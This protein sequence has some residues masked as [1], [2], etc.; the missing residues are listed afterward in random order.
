MNHSSTIPQ[1]VRSG[2][3]APALIG[4]CTF[5]VFVVVQ[6][7]AH[8]AFVARVAVDL[9][10]AI[11][12]ACREW[13]IW[14][15]ITPALFACVRHIQRSSTRTPYVLACL[16]LLALA[17]GFRTA[18]SVPEG[19]QEMMV[20][21]LY[22]FPKYLGTWLAVIVAGWLLYIGVKASESQS[23]AA[24]T[25]PVRTANVLLVSKGRD[26]CLVDFDHIDSFSSSRNYLDVRCDGQTYLLRSTL[27]QIEK[28]LP[29]GEF[30]RTHRSHIVRIRA[31]QRIRMLPSG[32]GLVFL[33]DGTAI[34]LSKQYYRSL[35]QYRGSPLICSGQT[36]G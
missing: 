18:M 24:S 9:A 16:G 15:V 19:T 36:V 3:L 26:Q 8:Q 29:A 7:L 28:S 5:A 6:C 13:G 10:D 4:W 31:I 22:F 20:T 14:V 35:N 12:C 34:A 23:S 25:E 1:Y 27:K 32:T 11:I 30:I 17:L 2:D 21:L 33:Q